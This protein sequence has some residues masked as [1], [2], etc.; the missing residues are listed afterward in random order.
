VNAGFNFVLVSFFDTAVTSGKFSIVS[1]RCCDGASSYGLAKQ[2][3]AKGVKVAISIGGDGCQG[4]AP[5]GL[6]TLSAAAIVQGWQDFITASGVAWSGIDFDWEGG[7]DNRMALAI[8]NVGAA[9]RPKGWIVTTAP[10]SSQF[11]PGGAQGWT[12]LNPANVDAVMPQWYQGGCVGTQ[13]CPC[14]GTQP[15]ST[16]TCPGFAQSYMQQSSKCGVKQWV[17]G[18]TKVGAYSWPASQIVIGVKSW[19]GGDVAATC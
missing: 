8:N 10:M 2:L 4:T 15:V 17:D 7:N 16:T 12:A 6:E 9:L 1:N 18:Y 5:T 3:L 11:V 13:S 14:W 19:C